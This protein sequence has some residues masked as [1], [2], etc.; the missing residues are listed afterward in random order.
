MRRRR[1]DLEHVD[2][3]PVAEPQVAAQRAARVR[4][5]ALDRARGEILVLAEPQAAAGRWRLALAVDDN[6][7]V[8]DR[9]LAPGEMFGMAVRQPPGIEHPFA[10]KRVEADVQLV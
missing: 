3:D 5:V 7:V 1:L 9:L 10:A 8:R 6:G 4:A 2:E